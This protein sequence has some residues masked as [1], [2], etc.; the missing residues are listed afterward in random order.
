MLANRSAT[1]N[2]GNLSDSALGTCKGNFCAVE[3]SFANNRRS[4][5]AP[6]GVSVAKHE[7]LEKGPT[8]H[9]LKAVDSTCD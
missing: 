4:C 7:N 1:I 6:S 3:S 8:L 2:I 9:R 5:R